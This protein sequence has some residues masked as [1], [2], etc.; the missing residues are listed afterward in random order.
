MEAEKDENSGDQDFISAG[1]NS[2]GSD[3]APSFN[4]DIVSGDEAIECLEMATPAETMQTLIHRL[5]L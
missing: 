3:R 1:R 5:E 4:K 2:F